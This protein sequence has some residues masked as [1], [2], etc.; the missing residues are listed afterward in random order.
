[1]EGG[2]KGGGGVGQERGRVIQWL[3]P[4]CEKCSPGV[5][6]VMTSQSKEITETCALLSIG[7]E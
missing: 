5:L 7:L 3:V 4:P 2:V 6:E 1:M